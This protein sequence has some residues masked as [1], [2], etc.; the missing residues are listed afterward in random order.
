MSLYSNES[1]PQALSFD[2]PTGAAFLALISDQVTRLG[3]VTVLTLP[4]IFFL[5]AI[6]N[7]FSLKDKDGNKIPSGP[8]G[9]GKCDRNCTG[10]MS[11]LVDFVPLL[12]KFDTPLHARGK[13]L[14]NDLVS[15]YGGL[16]KDVEKKMAWGVTVPDCL[17]KSMLGVREAEQLDN[18]DMAI[19]ASAFMIGGVETVGAFCEWESQPEYV[20]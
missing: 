13:K 19:L 1:E 16:I 6:T 12:Q 14:H 11:N 8:L 20:N 10:P 18:L 7:C 5:L 3:T 15:T 17:A 4:V 2:Q 9:L